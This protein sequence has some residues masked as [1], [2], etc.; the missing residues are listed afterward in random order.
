VTIGQIDPTTFGR[1][2]LP[3]GNRYLGRVIYTD[4]AI[5]M[6]ATQLEVSTR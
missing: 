5:N 2:G 6:A 1:T 3:A 4:G